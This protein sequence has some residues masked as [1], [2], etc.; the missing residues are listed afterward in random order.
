MW[1]PFGFVSGLNRFGM[2]DTSPLRAFIKKFFDSTTY[3]YKRKTAFLGVDMVNGDIDSFNETLSDEDKINAVM[4][5]S[6]IPIAFTTQHWDYNGHTIAGVDG[7]TAYMFDI[8]GAVNRCQ[9]LVDDDSKITVDVIGC[10]AAEQPPYSGYEKSQ[11]MDNWN[12]FQA[13]KSYYDGS[14][15]LVEVMAA[16]PKV[17]YRHY[18]WP[19]QAMPDASSMDGTN[20]TCTW[21]QKE[22]GRLDGAAA[23]DK[24]GV[25]F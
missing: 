5:S 13:I 6:A 25:I 3:E 2:V 23:V 22:I 1:W 15:D 14:S 16:F 4:T 21:P 24:E 12:R 10:Y 11:T 19:T 8:A 9:E 18:I 20:S 7:G 17:N